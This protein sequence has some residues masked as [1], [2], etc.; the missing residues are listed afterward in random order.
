MA[1][2]TANSTQSVTILGEGGAEKLLGRGDM[3]VQSPLV[4]RVGLVRAQGCY[5]QK[6]ET[7]RV[8]GYLKEHYETIYDEKYLNL[9]EQSEIEGQA[10]AMSGAVAAS[11][12][13]AEERRYQEIKSWVMS[14]QY[15]SMS[16]IQGEC[17]VGFNRARRFFTRLQQEGVVGLETEGNKGCRVLMH[18]D[19][20]AESIVTSDELTY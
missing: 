20:G 15:M 14:N 8:I 7:S 18:D 16:R 1:L 11:S 19:F 2:C 3:L 10:L 4:S 17:A 9:E 13:A 6:K 12:D 5:I